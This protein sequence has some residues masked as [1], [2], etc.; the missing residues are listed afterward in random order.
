MPQLPSNIILERLR[1][2]IPFVAAQRLRKF[3]IE[4]NIR[5]DAIGIV[6]RLRHC[7]AWFHPANQCENVSPIAL[8]VKIYWHKEI[9]LRSWCKHSSKIEARGQNPN[10]S[11]WLSVEF[12]SLTDD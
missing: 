7:H 12:N 3:H 11:D 6:Q 9:N 8:L 5:R 1:N 2:Q 4:I 10:D